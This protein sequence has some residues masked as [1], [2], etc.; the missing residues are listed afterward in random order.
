MY[1]GVVGL[2]VDIEQERLIDEFVE[3]Q[4]VPTFDSELVS[5]I[6]FRT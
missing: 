2:G 4:L 6:Y 5:R 1:G 3:S